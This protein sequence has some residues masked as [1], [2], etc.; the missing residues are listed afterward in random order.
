M[1]E[2]RRLIKTIL[3]NGFTMALG[4]VDERGVWVANV[5]YI[6]DEDYNL[7]W[8]SRVDTRHSEAVLKNSNVAA[9]ITLSNNPNKEVIGLQISGVAEKLQHDPVSGIVEAR[10]VKSNGT[11]PATP[12]GSFFPITSWYRLKPKRIELMHV[13][14]FGFNKKVLEL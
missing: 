13:P 1:E 12:E 6:H 11:S 3:E 8:L 5:T 4:T 14:L 9:A 2:L 7:Y 10:E